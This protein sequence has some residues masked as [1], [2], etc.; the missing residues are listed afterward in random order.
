MDNGSLS[1]RINNMGLADL[2][3]FDAFI[4]SKLAIPTEDSCLS[5]LSVACQ[6]A[7]LNMVS[8]LLDQDGVD[9]NAR[10]SDGMAAIHFL[11]SGEDSPVIRLNIMEQLYKYRANIDLVNDS[12]LTPIAV[13]SLHNQSGLV[14]FLIDSGCDV[15]KSDTEGSTPFSSACR[16]ASEGWYFFNTDSMNIST[17][18]EGFEQDDDFPPA[19][20]CR[21]LLKAGAN[22]TQATL[23]PSAILF[24][25]STVVKDFLDLGMDVNAIDENG[26]SPLDCACSSSY[27]PVD[28][29]QLLL[30]KGADVNGGGRSKPIISAYVRNSVD[31][32]KLLLS[33]G[34]VLSQEEMSELV[35]LGLSKCFLE[36]P[37]IVNEESEE[38]ESWKLLVKAGF[39]PKVSLILKNLN[40]VSLCSSYE[41]VKPIIDDLIFRVPTLQALSR[42]SIRSNM[43]PSVNIN[44]ETLP[45][46]RSVKCYLRFESYD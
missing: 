11:C 31:K 4:Q 14:N 3:D 9:V 24:S 15:N 45:I 41:Q 17:D 18:D 6:M 30:E 21:A 39:R 29:V 44:V 1:D 13:A 25:N 35:S 22:S 19:L 20:I 27:I 38:L 40:R 23:L 26:R 5:Q 43:R 34:A 46:P 37:D 28:M 7:N 8:T 10:G 36:N 16:L 2:N 33:Y 12:G 42:I 32:I